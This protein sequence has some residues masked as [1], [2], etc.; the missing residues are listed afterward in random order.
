LKGGHSGVDIHEGRA[1]ALKVLARAQDLALTHEAKVATIDGGSKRNAL[2]REASALLTLSPSAVP[3]LEGALEKLQADVRAEIGKFDTPVDISLDPADDFPEGVFSGRDA[4]RIVSFLQGAPHGVL[5]WSPD[6]PNLVQTS[7]NL[8]VIS[9]EGAKVSVS[10]S[11]RS[12]RDSAK[13]DASDSLKA[14]ALLAGFAV[15]QGDGY[16]G[17]APNPASPL[18]A[19]ARRVHEEV[20]GFDPEVK[21]IHAGLECGIISEKYPAIDVISFGPTIR[22]AHSPDET[23]SIPSVAGF[24]RYLNALLAKD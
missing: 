13:R 4:R 24:W 5:A 2:P 23:V 19:V 10:T 7:T 16:P 1:N 9:T 12:P 18:L 8:A 11:Q 20:F 21:A 14:V 17:W 3:V 22:N 6:V 15:E